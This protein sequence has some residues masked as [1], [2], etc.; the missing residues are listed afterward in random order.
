[1]R[2]PMDPWARDESAR[3]G[4]FPD[5]PGTHLPRR[6]SALRPSGALVLL[7]A[8]LGWAAPALAGATQSGADAPAARLGLAGPSGVGSGEAILPG[9]ARAR[10]GDARAELARWRGRSCTPAG[11]AGRAEAPGSAPAG[12]AVAA[13]ATLVAA[14][15][16]PRP[17]G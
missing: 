11:C 4:D 13:L 10:Q 12:F 1:M 3:G 5:L 14:R 17:R 8:L 6:I 9:P 7:A 2:L 16:R 15:R